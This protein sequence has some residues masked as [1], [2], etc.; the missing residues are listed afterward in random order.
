[1]ES[2]RGTPNKDQIKSN[3]MFDRHTKLVVIFSFFL[4]YLVTLTY[5]ASPSQGLTWKIPYDMGCTEEKEIGHIL[6]SKIFKYSYN[7][8]TH[9]Q[10]INFLNNHFE[11]RIKRL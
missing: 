5:S 7:L 10:I 6:V 11:V 2:T 9:T 4:C 3:K 1:M 8:L